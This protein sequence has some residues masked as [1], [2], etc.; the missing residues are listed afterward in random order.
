VIIGGTHT[1]FLAA[2]LR[3]LDA[4]RQAHEHNIANVE[5]PHFRAQRVNFEDSL[6][7]AMQVDDPR[8]MGMT[9]NRSTDATRPDGNNVRLDK[10]LTAVE[11]N[12]LRQQLMTAALNHTYGRIRAALGR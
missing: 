1:D 12:A 3:G 2:A 6:R 9:V 5:T 11:A 8:S 7:R 4:Q 10:E